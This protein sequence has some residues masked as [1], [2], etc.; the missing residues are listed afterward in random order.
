M[1]ETTFTL[2]SR[3]FRKDIRR[4]SRKTIPRVA[5]KG[6]SAAGK[7]WMKDCLSVTPTVPKD[8]GRLR[9]SGSVITE[10]KKTAT[11]RDVMSKSSEGWVH[12][13]KSPADLDNRRPP[14]KPFVFTAVVGWNT[15]YAK[16][17]HDAEESQH[18]NLPGSGG[19]FL[20]NKIAGRAKDYMKA[21]ADV[22][23]QEVAKKKKKK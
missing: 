6:L 8:T 15:E 7:M 23:K 10:G 4:I 19:G 21:V 20:A 3:A 14:K 1:S 12:G 2:D 9:S 5:K 22:F 11:S 17:V 16:K 18:F 13:P